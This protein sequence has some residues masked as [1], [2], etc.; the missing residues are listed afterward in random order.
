MRVCRMREERELTAEVTL[1]YIF[2]FADTVKCL[3]L[4]AKAINLLTRKC[5]DGFNATQVIRIVL[6]GDVPDTKD[7]IFHNFASF[8]KLHKD[9]KEKLEGKWG[10]RYS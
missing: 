9:F 10:V 8:I 6:D 4:R 2:E 1:K 3:S 5:G 7:E